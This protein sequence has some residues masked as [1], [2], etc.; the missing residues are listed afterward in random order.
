M[1][2]RDILTSSPF[3]YRRVRCGQ[4]KETTFLPL[5]NLP[6]N[7]FMLPCCYHVRAFSMKKNPLAANSPRIQL[8]ATRPR[9]N[10]LDVVAC[11]AASTRLHKLSSIK[12]CS[13]SQGGWRGG[14]GSQMCFRAR[15]VRYARGRG[16]ATRSKTPM[17]LTNLPRNHYTCCYHARAFR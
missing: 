16:E 5:T 6:R 12:I 7:H 17:P 15:F 10:R 3:F 4:P 1:V 2:K 11:R 8:S 13:F 9:S 14:S